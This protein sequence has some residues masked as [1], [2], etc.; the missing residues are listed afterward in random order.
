MTMK[1]H[2]IAT[3]LLLC[4]LLLGCSAESPSYIP[5][6][7]L[8]NFPDS[9]VKDGI[10]NGKIVLDYGADDS[11]LVI[12]QDLLEFI[13]KS[14]QIEPYTLIQY[15]HL[16]GLYDHNTIFIGTCHTNP[17]NNFVNLFLDCLSMEKDIAIIRYVEQDNVTIISVAGYSIKDTKRAVDVMMNY[18][19]YNLS[20]KEIEVR[21]D[22]DG[23]PFV[24]ITG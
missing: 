10:F 9:F 8:A 4:L 21:N 1:L 5:K 22:E 19:D 24:R 7:G 12:G 16:S 11:E 14:Y 13:V 23:N 3:V 20:G 15:N 17:K 18:S 2:L 6:Q